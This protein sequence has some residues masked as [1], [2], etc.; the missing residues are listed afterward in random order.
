MT[1][2]RILP[3]NVTAK[4]LDAALDEMRSIVVQNM[5]D[6][7][8]L[9]KI[10]DGSYVNPPKSHDVFFTL[11]RDEFVNSAVV[12]PGSTEDVRA[13]VV[14]ANKFKIPSRVDRNFGY[15]GDAPTRHTYI[16]ASLI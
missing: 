10:E 16:C 3:S 9:D 8:D 1:S 4:Q 7:V 15:S 2:G 14:V 11:E 12:R 13:I 6:F 5:W